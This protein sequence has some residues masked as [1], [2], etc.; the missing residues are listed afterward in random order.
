MPHLAQPGRVL[1]LAGRILEAQ[2]EQ[3]LMGLVQVARYL[4]LR[5]VANLTAGASDFLPNSRRTNCVR[6]G[7]LWEA[8]RIASR[9]SSSVR[10]ATSNNMRPGPD[11]GRPE[12]DCALA[13]THAGLGRSL[14]HRMIGEDADPQLATAAHDSARWRGGLLRSGGWSARLVPAPATQNRRSL[15]G[16]HGWHMPRRRPRMYLAVFHT[17]WHQ[18]D[19]NS[20]DCGFAI[21]DRG[22][23][24]PSVNPK[25]DNPQLLGPVGARQV[26][27]L[28]DPDLDADPAKGGQRLV[29]GIVDLGPQ[30]VA[31]HLALHAPSPHGPF[32]HR[33]AGR[34][35]GSCSPWRRPAWPA[36]WPA[37]WHASAKCG[38]RADRRCSRPPAWHP[39]QA[40]RSRQCP[41]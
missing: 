19:N 20:S 14:R 25:S 40:A 38:A 41:A 13:A 21:S 31:G 22:F 6:M 36:T 5:Q 37:S 17:L 18:H 28:V 16:C 4:S 8:N 23:E 26:L 11:H 32:R 3:L 2:V 24:R 34:H 1:Q 33:T 30:C 39:A 10:P 15:P 27:A 12:L 29:R 9:A 7:S 35:S